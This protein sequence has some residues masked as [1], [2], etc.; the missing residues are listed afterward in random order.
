MREGSW[1]RRRTTLEVDSPFVLPTV[2]GPT[3]IANRTEREEKGL[4]TRG[5]GSSCNDRL[6]VPFDVGGE[7]GGWK[8]G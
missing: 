4:V 7:G 6:L 1:R 3:P 5:Y 2:L 8:S